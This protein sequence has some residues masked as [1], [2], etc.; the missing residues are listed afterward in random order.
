MPRAQLEPPARRLD[1]NA[2]PTL[3]LIAVTFAAWWMVRAAIAQREERDFLAEYDRTSDGIIIGA[4]PI[5]L[6]GTR[7]GGVLLFHGYNDSPQ[8]LASLASSLH[9]HGWTV[10]VALLPGH[11]RTLPAFAASGAVA[12]IEGAQAEFANFKLE[13]PV[14]AI[15]G[16]SMGGALAM[17]VAADDPEVRAVLMFAPYLHA[18]IP[19]HLLHVLAPVATLGARYVTSGGARSVHDPAASKE[20]I[21]YRRSTPRLL[22]QLEKVVHRARAALPRV[23]QPVLVVQSREDNRIPSKVA[24]EAF[25]QIGSTDKTMHW[26]TGNGHVVTVDYGHERLEELAAEWLE[27][28]LP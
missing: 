15:G 10:R 28:R 5:H 21:A 25:A 24:S 19:L 7:R 16:L 17:I 13:C 12:W 22:V 4:Q 6:R 2:M 8:S 20:M 18:S 14:A 9:K 11:G 23:H 1:R 3:L 26:S 27:Q